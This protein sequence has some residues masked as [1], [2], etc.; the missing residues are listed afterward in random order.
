M[1]FDCRK[2][3]VR[4]PLFSRIT[5][6]RYFGIAVAVALL[7][8]YLPSRA[9]AECGDY[10]II[11]NKTPGSKQIVQT[12]AQKPMEPTSDH[13]RPSQ[14]CRGPNCSSNPNKQNA[15]LAIPITTHNDSKESTAQFI[16]ESASSDCGKWLSLL[17]STDSPISISPRI[18]HPPRLF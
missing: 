18:F 12:N 10:V 13:N 1:D 15:P 3:R 16:P 7:L 17:N 9:K 14:P 2:V 5:G 6:L 8:G 11:L 4:V